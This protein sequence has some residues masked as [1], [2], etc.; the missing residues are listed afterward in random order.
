MT[1][2]LHDDENYHAKVTA[3]PR[4]FSANRRAKNLKKKK[5]K[6]F[7]CRTSQEQAQGR[8]NLGMN[9][10]RLQRLYAPAERFRG[11]YILNCKRNVAQKIQF[12]IL[13]TFLQ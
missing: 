9:T 5:Y 2:F 3:V 11:L 12:S 10:V 4:L 13:L 7:I 8:N 6:T 1:Q